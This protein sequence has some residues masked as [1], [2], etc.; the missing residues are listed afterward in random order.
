M[1]I[2]VICLLAYVYA[3]YK[4][5]KNGLV[6]ALFSLAGYVLAY[7][8]AKHFSHPVTGW[9]ASF[10]GS[11]SKWLPVIVYAALFISVWLT[12]RIAA[13]FVEKGLQLLSLGIINKIGGVLFY[14][15]SLTL[16]LWFI[17]SL[18]SYIDSPSSQRFADSFFYKHVFSLL[19]SVQDLIPEIKNAD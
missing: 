2:D 16:L 8:A 17:F 6:L 14:V 12:I 11:S 3:V 18:I 7:F 15:A 10:S 19:P 5:L 9:V 13:S 4:G 1:I